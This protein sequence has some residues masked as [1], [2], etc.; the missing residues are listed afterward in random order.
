ML[1]VQLPHQH[2]KNPSYVLE[3]MPK[4]GDFSAVSE[5]FHS[6]S[7]PKRL[8]LFWL[9]CHYE[10]CV[11]N[12]SAL[13]GMS[14]PALSHHLKV[15]KAQGLIKSRR[16]GKEMY[17]TAADGEASRLLH[18]MIE[19][20]VDI[21][22]PREKSEPFTKKETAHCQIILVWAAFKLGKRENREDFSLSHGF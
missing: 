12:L 18:H 19:M 3:D 20:L 11:I 9:L 10:E 16:V 4:D 7:D 8:K 13:M 14:S 22:C 6:V 17:Y 2:G 1:M 5:I 21:S 15:L